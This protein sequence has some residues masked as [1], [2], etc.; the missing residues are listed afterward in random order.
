MRVAGFTAAEARRRRE[1]NWSLGAE[2]IKHK[3]MT[4]TESVKKC[5]R[6]T[7]SFS[8][9]AGREEFWWFYLFGVIASLCISAVVNG[10]ELICLKTMDDVMPVEMVLLVGSIFLFGLNLC[11]AIPQISVTVRRLH[12]TSHSGWWFWIMLIPIVGWIWFLVLMIK[13]SDGPNEY[14]NGPDGY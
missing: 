14:G 6:D 8:G 4:F 5:F 10:G 13:E 9:R 7:F 12:D 2:E 11:I 3:N 1:K